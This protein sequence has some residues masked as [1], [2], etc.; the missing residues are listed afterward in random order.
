MSDPDLEEV[1]KVQQLWSGYGWILRCYSSAL[2]HN[3]IAKYIAPPARS[4]RQHPRGW[5]TQ[6]SHQRKLNSYRVESE[7]YRLYAERTDEFCVVPQAVLCQ[8]KNDQ[9]LLIVTDLNESGF[10]ER[11]DNGNLYL[12]MQGLIWLANFH[13]TFMFC[14]GQGLWSQGGYWHLSTRQDELKAMPDIPLKFQANELD[15][16]LQSAQF[17]TLIHGDAKL[18]NMCFEP[19][20]GRVA[21]VDFQYVGRGAGIVD[22]V[23]FLSSA[24]SENE[25]AE[26]HQ[27][28]LTYYFEQLE[29]ALV[30]N[31]IPVPFAEL[32]SEYR[33]LYTIAWADFY[34]FLLGWNPQSWKINPFI[35][36]MSEQALTQLH[37]GQAQ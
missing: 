36:S 29:Q 32:E 33:Q 10:T 27:A 17:Q 20:S 7:F 30:R 23:Y 1:E 26:H 14:D 16:R 5:N 19:E 18:Q 11:R 22:F 37:H 6:T 4:E 25:L 34:R 8:S 2:G 15:S 28:L 24:L 9:S 35:A 31:K 21:A 13:A 3:V 12:V